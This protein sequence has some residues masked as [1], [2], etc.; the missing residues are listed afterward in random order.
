MTFTLP[1]LSNRL[2][3]LQL[4]NQFY[5]K[6]TMSK[7]A[8]IGDIHGYAPALKLALEWCR[9]ENVD[10]IVGLGD[11]VDGYNAN[12]KCVQL[13]Q[14]NFAACVR[15]NH[16]EASTRTSTVAFQ[17]TGINRIRRL[18]GHPFVPAS[19]TRRIHQVFRRRLELF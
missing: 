4:A 19:T 5:L 18:A 7:I 9:K 15:G 13:I 2:I 12:D 16:D 3:Q 11:F 6:L 14:E 8:F 10:S 1:V 17:A